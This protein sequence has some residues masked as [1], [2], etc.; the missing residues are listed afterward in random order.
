M[1]LLQCCR[2][3]CSLLISVSSLKAIKWFILF[4]YLIKW[5]FAVLTL[6]FKLSSLKSPYIY[7]KCIHLASTHWY[8]C[9]CFSQRIIMLQL[10]NPLLSLTGI[11]SLYSVISTEPLSSSWNLYHPSFLPVI[12]FHLLSCLLLI[13]K[14]VYSPMILSSF[15]LLYHL[16]RLPKSFVTIIISLMLYLYL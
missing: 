2:L 4:R 10:P 6:L 5:L 12:N 7:S 13:L 16:P 9:S 11:L 15:V 8:Y 3:L 14:N 1:L